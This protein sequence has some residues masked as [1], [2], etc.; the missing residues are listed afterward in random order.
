[1]EIPH[2]RLHERAF[3]LVPLA[4]IARDLVHP[5]LKMTVQELLRRVDQKGVR[6]V[7]RGLKL[8]IEHDVQQAAPLVP[9]SL[10]RAGVTNL[11]RIIQIADG[12]RGVLFYAELDIFADLKPEQ[13]GV[14]MSRFGDVLEGLT[15]EISLRTFSGH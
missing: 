10:S 6:R 13:A 4:E 9:V 14:H 11:R 12:G 1:M 7:Q 8:R 15:A 3:V 5:A 2:P